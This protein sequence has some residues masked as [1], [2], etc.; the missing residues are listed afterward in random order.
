[1]IV[2]SRRTSD[3]EL[4]FC[5]PWPRLHPWV[6]R[7][8]DIT[9]T[10]TCWWLCSDGDF[11]W[12]P[13]SEIRLNLLSYAV[14]F[15][16]VLSF[17]VFCDYV[18]PLILWYSEMVRACGPVTFIWFWH[19]CSGYLLI[20]GPWSHPCIHKHCNC[21]L[22][23][24]FLP[25]PRNHIFEPRAELFHLIL[26]AKRSKHEGSLEMNEHVIA[27]IPCIPYISCI[28]GV[29]SWSSLFRFGILFRIANVTSLLRA[30]S[31]GIPIQIWF[32]LQR[33]KSWPLTITS[34]ETGHGITLWGF[35]WE[36]SS[37]EFVYDR[38]ASYGPWSRTPEQGKQSIE[39]PAEPG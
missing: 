26:F 11:L 24:R 5:L 39:D 3:P 7:D 20:M 21:I 16:L 25:F 22:A 18:G 8:I 9:G 35:D 36:E 30:Q 29:Q 28:T 23:Y 34:S 32:S 31:W 19:Q 15:F 13:V 6:G 1:M 38:H 12:F 37:V 14:W 27:C 2:F 33:C 10:G 17:L 4:P